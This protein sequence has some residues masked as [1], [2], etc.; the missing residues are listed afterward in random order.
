MR[1]IFCLLILTAALII[2]G[3]T[4]DKM[5]VESTDDNQIKIS[6]TNASD[7]GTSGHI[8]IPDGAALHVDAKITAGKLIIDFGDRKQTVDKSGEFF[9]DVPVGSYDL[10]LNAEDGLTGEITLRALPK[11]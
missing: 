4:V 11:V 7:G 9:I 2:G 3:C 6:A 8:K 5:T 1:K 10:F